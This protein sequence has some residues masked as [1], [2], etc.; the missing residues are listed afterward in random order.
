MSKDY[1]E[2]FCDSRP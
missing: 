1:F 2:M